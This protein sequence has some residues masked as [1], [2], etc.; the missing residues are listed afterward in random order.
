MRYIKI[1]LVCTLMIFI[2]TANASEQKHSIS[3]GIGVTDGAYTGAGINLKYRYEFNEKWGAGFSYTG[4]ASL[5]PGIIVNSA[6]GYD[7]FSV[8]PFY[9]ISPS[10]S[11]YAL[12]GIASA[13]Q[14]EQWI[15]GNTINHKDR[16]AMGA[17]GLQINPWQSVVID[18]SWEYSR[19]LGENNNTWILGI[20]YRF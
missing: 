9:R 16:G 12:A 7:A 15:T 10:L 1:L 11:I 20:G 3:A 5:M 18:A 8:G 2:T 19:L 17:L 4:I 13:E 14:E 6:G